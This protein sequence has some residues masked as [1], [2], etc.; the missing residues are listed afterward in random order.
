M[1]VDM[2]VVGGPGIKHLLR[3]VGD[4]SGNGNGNGNSQVCI[5]IQ[6]YIP[7]R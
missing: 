2:Y 5:W 6:K 3:D 7:G 1:Y 4:G